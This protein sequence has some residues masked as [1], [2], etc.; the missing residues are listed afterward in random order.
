MLKTLTIVNER[1]AVTSVGEAKCV[2]REGSLPWLQGGESPVN[3]D[4]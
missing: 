1:G 3:G 4:P 2:S